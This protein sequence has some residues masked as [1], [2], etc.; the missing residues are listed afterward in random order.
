MYRKDLMDKTGPRATTMDA[1]MDAVKKIHARSPGTA[2]RGRPGQLKSGHYSLNCDWTCWLWAHG[3]SI[4]DKAGM[5]SGG[6]AAGLEGPCLHAGTGQAHAAG[7]D[8]LDLGRHG[9]VGDAGQAAMLISWGEFFPGF[10]GKDSQVSQDGG[11]ATP[12]GKAARRRTPV[13][14]RSRR[15]PPGRLGDRLS[16]YSRTRR[17]LD[18]HAVGLLAG[19]D[20][21]RVHPR[22]RRLAHAHLSFEDPRVKAMAKVGRGRPGTSTRSSGHRQTPWVRARHAGLGGD[23]Q[24]RGAGGVGQAARRQYRSGKECMDAIK[25]QADDMAKPFRT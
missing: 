11:G 23:L 1:Y 13:S 3:G 20:G 25:R 7:G 10:D 15:R 9:P 19:C 17:G 24:Q 21:P 18:L 2:S 16:K 14:A 6:D 5:F 12:A 22:R 4:F 8:H